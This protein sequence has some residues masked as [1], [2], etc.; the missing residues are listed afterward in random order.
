MMGLSFLS[1]WRLLLL[2]VVLALG[3]LYVAF[4]WRR[5]KYAVKFTNLDL[6][7]TVAPKRPGWRRHVTAGVQL[8]ALATLVLA[9]AQPT[10]ET[11]V[12]RERA[13]VVMAVDVSLSM[14]ADDVSPDRI[15]A[16]KVAATSFLDDVPEAVNV[17]LVT[18]AG[19]ARV[20]VS[21]TTDRQAIA[22]A[23]DSVELREG[24]AIGDAID[25]SLDSLQTVPESPDEEP[26]PAAIVVM[27]DGSTT[28]GVPNEQ[29]TQ[30][31]IDEGVPV[32]TIAFGTEDGT[33]TI[34]ETG[35]LVRVPVDAEALAAI[36]DETGGQ[37]YEASTQSELTDVYAS[38][39][40]SIG[41]DTVD[42][43]ITEWFVAGA[44]VGF[45]IAAG[46][47]LAWTNRIP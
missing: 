38:I 6:L 44:L 32:S 20:E 30:R 18:F 34:P 12:P 39:G 16:A 1:P 15:A 43:E 17:G 42:S 13:T 21:P 14:L 33:V 19:T 47:A 41:Y 8:L 27:S 31:A 29:A 5:S 10:H 45:V 3:A 46:F 7:A 2:L 25:A 22:A 23:I 40:S 11:K 9:F 28:M 35:E 37:T 4:Q 24:T 36:A 26:V